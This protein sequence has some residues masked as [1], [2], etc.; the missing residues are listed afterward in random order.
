MRNLISNYIIIL[1]KIDDIFFLTKELTIILVVLTK[2]KTRYFPPQSVDESLKIME[3][4]RVPPPITRS[5]SGYGW[6]DD[7]EDD[8][9]KEDGKGIDEYEA[10]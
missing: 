9:D 4:V 7:D 8:V 5:H 2:K 10:K 3:E 1:S 6:E